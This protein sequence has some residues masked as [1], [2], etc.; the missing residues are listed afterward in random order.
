MTRSGYQVSGP[1]ILSAVR[2]AFDGGE[3][4]RST[5]IE[6]RVLR[7]CRHLIGQRSPDPPR[8]IAGSP[9]FNQEVSLP[10]CVHRLPETVVQISPK[11]VTLGE[12]L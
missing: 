7:Q 3:L 12:R 10:Y 11:L 9:E 2:Y 6:T 8:C 4:P 1:V 5:K